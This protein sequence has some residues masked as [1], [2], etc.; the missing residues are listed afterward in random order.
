MEGETSNSTRTYAH[1][2]TNDKFVP[3]LLRTI[4][5][6]KAPGPFL[7]GYEPLSAIPTK[8]TLSLRAKV[9]G[10]R[11]IMRGKVIEL[12]SSR[13]RPVL[14]QTWL[15]P[16]TH[17]SSTVRASFI[18]NRNRNPVGCTESVLR[19]GLEAARHDDSAIQTPAC[20]P[21]KKDDPKSGPVS[22][23]IIHHLAPSKSFWSRRPQFLI[24]CQGLT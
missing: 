3:E 12:S 16:P 2:R 7:L 4:L 5:H 10:Q 19:H 8:S 9:I 24:S 22:H 21:Y 6:S 13:V 14:T 18:R 23:P 15:V 20:T 11:V 1:W 17:S